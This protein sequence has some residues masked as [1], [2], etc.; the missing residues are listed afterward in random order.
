MIY[1]LRVRFVAAE[2]G[3]ETRIFTS[4]RADVHDAAQWRNA[5]GTS[6]VTRRDATRRT[7]RE[8]GSVDVASQSS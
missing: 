8:P 5:R 4:R 1:V 3:A 2:R 7:A 6:R